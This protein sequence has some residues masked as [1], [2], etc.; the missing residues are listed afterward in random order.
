MIQLAFTISAAKAQSK[1]VRFG[2]P[3]LAGL[4]LFAG[5][6]SYRQSGADTARST[7]ALA[8]DYP[9]TAWLM[10]YVMVLR[11]RVGGSTSRQGLS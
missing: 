7:T 2:R 5:I 4:A 1:F 6:S 3:L 8:Y 10:Y 11:R 9:V